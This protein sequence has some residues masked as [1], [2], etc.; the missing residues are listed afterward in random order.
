[1]DYTEINKILAEKPLTFKDLDGKEITF[2]YVPSYEDIKDLCGRNPLIKFDDKTPGAY[3]VY[4]DVILQGL[5]DYF[6]HSFKGDNERLEDV[7]ID[8]VGSVQAYYC[9]EIDTFVDSLISRYGAD[10]VSLV[11]VFD[12]I[13]HDSLEISAIPDNRCSGTYAEIIRSLVEKQPYLKDVLSE[14]E[15]SFGASDQGDDLFADLALLCQ[16]AT[17]EDVIVELG[18]NDKVLQAPLNEQGLAVLTEI[19]PAMPYGIDDILAQI[20]VVDFEPMALGCLFDVF[21]GHIDPLRE[22]DG[23][24]EDD[25]ALI[26]IYKEAQ[27]EIASFY[28]EQLEEQVSYYLSQVANMEEARV[29]CAE[30]GQYVESLAFN[31][32]HYDPNSKRLVDAFSKISPFYVTDGEAYILSMLFTELREQIEARDA[33][34]NKQVDH[35]QKDKSVFCYP[36]ASQTPYLH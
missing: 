6:K 10:H 20:K 11:A 34:L 33:V 23:P 16:E 32:Q 2:D 15:E 18:I 1:M 25:L 24:S 7:L 28:L 3:T 27:N 8:L 26:E 9:A 29:A 13:L 35:S 19:F 14:L 5:Q 4:P 31:E 17:E 30:L 22:K 21:E 12:K 36:C